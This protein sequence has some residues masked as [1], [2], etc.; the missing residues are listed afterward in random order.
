MFHGLMHCWQPCQFIYLLVHICLFQQMSNMQ[1]I[2]L[3][4]KGLGQKKNQNMK[5]IFVKKE[6]KRYA[7]HNI[8]KFLFTLNTHFT[9]CYS[10]Y[11]YCLVFQHITMSNNATVCQ[12]MRKQPCG[13]V[14]NAPLWPVQEV[15]QTCNMKG[16]T[17]DEALAFISKTKHFQMP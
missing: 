9:C 1:M 10:Q 6:K 17:L 4:L 3:K 12:V 5:S 13:F 2:V 11:F 15:T 16:Y 14:C 8:W 7:M